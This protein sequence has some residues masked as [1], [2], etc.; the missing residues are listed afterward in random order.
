MKWNHNLQTLRGKSLREGNGVICSIF[1]PDKSFC[2]CICSRFLLFSLSAS[3][4]QMSPPEPPL[5][6]VSGS[7]LTQHPLTLMGHG[8]L[9]EVSR[10]TAEIETWTLFG[11]LQHWHRKTPILWHFILTHTAFTQLDEKT[12]SSSFFEQCSKWCTKLLLRQLLYYWR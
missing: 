4:C 5:S 1:L 3:H 12:Y 11:A 7:L 9:Y 6:D 8:T 2:R 10:V